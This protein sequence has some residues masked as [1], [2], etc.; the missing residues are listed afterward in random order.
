VVVVAYLAGLVF[1]CLFSPLFLSSFSPCTQ[2]LAS[3]RFVVVVAY[4]AGLF[5]SCFSPFC[6]L[7]VCL[8]FFYFV[9]HFPLLFLRSIVSKLSC[10]QP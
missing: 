3:G 6:M 10:L 4:V 5:F 8:C 9:F 7:L 2:D 1:V